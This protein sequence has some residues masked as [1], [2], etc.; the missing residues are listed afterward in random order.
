MKLV[1]GNQPNKFSSHTTTLG[2]KQSTAENSQIPV[3]QT[4][5]LKR[6]YIM[7]DIVVQALRGVSISIEPGEFTA[8]MGP[9]GSGKSTL[10]HL[11]GCLD[12]PTEGNLLIDGVST[13][14]LKE[15]KL[16]YLRNKKIGFVF[17]QFN[18]LNRISILENVETPLLYAGVSPRKRRKLALEALDRVGLGDRVK[19]RPTEL[20]G[21]QKQRAAIA[22]AIVNNPS[23]L[24]A[25]EPTG[26]LDTRTGHQILEL[27]HELNTQGLTVLMVTHDPEVG[28]ACRRVLTI[29]D[30]LISE[31]F[32]GNRPGTT[33]SQHISQGIVTQ[34]FNT[35]LDS[36]EDSPQ[37][38]ASSPTTDPAQTQGKP[39]EVML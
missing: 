35:G 14:K 32:T 16:A 1:T 7:G 27:F 31:E 38:E 5:D 36:G 19:H 22:R 25:D 12:T 9:S 3:I 15:A 39:T 8:I 20:S 34:E 37:L 4:I 17:Q 13:R 6:F 2:Q 28:D 23:L 21:G 29:R 11:I 24:M 18:L 10:M 30:G 26:A 33:A